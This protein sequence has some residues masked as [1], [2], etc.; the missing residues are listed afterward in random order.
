MN[1]FVLEKCK[2]V[3]TFLSRCSC[4]LP[5][6]FSHSFSR[7]NLFLLPFCSFPKWSAQVKV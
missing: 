3:H 7:F 5:L 6:T 2:A 1:P 4:F